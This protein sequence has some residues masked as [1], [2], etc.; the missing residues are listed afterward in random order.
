[1][2]QEYQNSIALLT[3]VVD[4]A[5]YIQLVQQLNKD[6]ELV[7]LDITFNTQN[8]PVELKNKLQE[9]VKDLLLNNT[10]DYYNL[11]Y[12]ID[13]SETTLKSINTSTIE[14]YT[15]AVT[16]LILKRIWLKVYYK[17]KFSS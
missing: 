1:M 7:S 10:D 15:E 14:D 12:R 9:T 11:L 2:L 8:S 6:F 5:L 3:N 17:N 4:K 16:F 13:V